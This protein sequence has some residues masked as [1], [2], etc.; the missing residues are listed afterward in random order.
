MKA[1]RLFVVKSVVWANQHVEKYLKKFWNLC[2]ILWNTFYLKFMPMAVILKI[3]MTTLKVR[4]N[5]QKAT[6][7]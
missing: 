6:P 3:P 5:M 1:T 7:S 4:L 2:V